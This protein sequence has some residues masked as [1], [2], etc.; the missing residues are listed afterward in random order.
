MK[1][2]VIRVE[3]LSTCLENWKA[4]TSAV[5]R[6]GDTHLRVGVPPPFDPETGQIVEA[7]IERQ[8]E[9]VLEQMKLCLERGSAPNA[10]SIA[11]PSTNLRRSMRSM[12]AI[13]RRTRRLAPL[14]VFRRGRGHLTSRLTA[15]QRCRSRRCFRCCSRFTESGSMGR[16][17]RIREMLRP[18][19]R[20]EGFVDNIRYR[21]L[22][23]EGSC[24]CRAGGTKKRL[25]AGAQRCGITRYSRKAARRCCSTIIC[26]FA[27]YDDTKSPEGYRL[28]EQRL[29]ET[30]VGAGTTVT[31]VDGRR[32]PE[33]VKA[34]SAVDVAKWLDLDPEAAGLVSWDVFDAGADAR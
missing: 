19:S 17:S 6:C 11:R 12:P 14:F 34:N 1:R 5:T 25:F 32:S 23:R 13:F 2:Q 9:I 30:E 22:T 21:S 20:S 16:L 15:L 7:P 28:Q 26:G 29:D 8:T 33:W 10:M 3:P 31:L 27:N 4:P 18:R 24:R